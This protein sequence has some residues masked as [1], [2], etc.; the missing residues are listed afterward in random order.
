ME[1]PPPPPIPPPR[2]P[3]APPPVSSRSIPRP[4]GMRRRSVTKA[5]INETEVAQAI[6]VPPPLPPSQ[7]SSSDRNK[8]ANRRVS[9]LDETGVSIETGPTPPPP[10]PPSQVPLPPSQVS[11]PSSQV[12]LPLSTTLSSPSVSPPSPVPPSPPSPPPLPPPVPS[13]RSTTPPPPSRPMAGYAPSTLDFTSL[14]SPPTDNRH[15]NTTSNSQT[16]SATLGTETSTQ[17]SDNWSMKPVVEMTQHKK[18]HDDRVSQLAAQGEL[19]LSRPK[20][21]RGGSGSGRRNT[22]LGLKNGTEIKRSFQLDED[23]TEL[24][25]NVF[26]LLDKDMDGLLQEDQLLTALATVGINPTRRIKYELKKRLPRSKNGSTRSEGVGL[27]TFMRIIRST[28]LAQPTAVTEIDALTAMYETP[29]R[30]GVIKGHQ[31]R[32][33]LEGV[34][35]SSNTKLS[36]TETDIIFQSLGIMEDADVNIHQYIDVVSDG[37]LRVVD[38]KRVGDN[39]HRKKLTQKSAQRRISIRME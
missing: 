26:H 24:L 9:F 33:L 7:T 22:V 2:P 1:I 4:P 25:R 29:D 10:L 15:A 11:L 31:L 27:D 21:Q 16:T 23:Q 32:H 8:P 34:E 14:S 28:L 17:K 37:F 38:H 6:V 35:T 18:I 39:Y 3:S 19:P 30:P 12:P 13:P 5:D 20:G 36:V